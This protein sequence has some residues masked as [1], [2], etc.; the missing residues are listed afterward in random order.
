MV[1][2]GHPADRVS[3]AREA[4]RVHLHVALRLAGDRQLAAHRFV[5]P[6]DLRALREAVERW[7]WRGRQAG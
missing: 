6:V 2:H 1:E 7:A 5:A 4:H 3:L